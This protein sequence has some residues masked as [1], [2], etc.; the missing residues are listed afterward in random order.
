[1]AIGLSRVLDSAQR[2]FWHQAFFI[3]MVI[4]CVGGIIELTQP[5]FGRS[6]NWRDLG[7]DLLGGLFGLIFLVPSRHELGGRLLVCVQS[8]VLVIAVVAFYSPVVTLWDMWQASRQFPLLSDFETRFEAKRWSNGEIEDS[9]AR[10]GDHSLGVVLGTEKY[11]GT[12]LRRSF[13][14]WRG[15]TTFALSLYNPDDK[16]LFVTVSIRDHEHNRRG[17]EFN[18]RFNRKF[19][20]EKG[21]K[22]ISIPIDDIQNTPSGR[23]LELDRLSEVVIFTVDLPEP[24]RIFLDNVRLMP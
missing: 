8:F 16:P 19:K 20:I 5:Y 24:R 12:T 13:G 11:A 23:E 10:H 7:I 1:M 4:F 6:A 17:G 15:Y 21:W 2:T 18:D 22:D 9:I 3:L 14:D